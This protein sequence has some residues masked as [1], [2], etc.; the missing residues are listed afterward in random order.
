[1][2]N[3]TVLDCIRLNNRL[4]SIYQNSKDFNKH[5]YVFDF[6][7]DVL[8]NLKEKSKENAI[9]SV[10]VVEELKKW[11][12]AIDGTVKR[13]K[14]YHK[15]NP[16]IEEFLFNTPIENVPLYIKDECLELYARWRLD[17]CK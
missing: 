4:Q 11:A 10:D 15:N 14:S 13:S 6:E 5:L 3:Y 2:P 7:A 17:I 16:S 9:T 8:L 12:A 1:M